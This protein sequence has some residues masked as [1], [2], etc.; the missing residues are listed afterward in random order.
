M[1]LRID[2]EE[3]V[4]R[5]WIS[6]AIADEIKAKGGKGARKGGAHSGSATKVD[7]QTILYDALCARLPGLP[8]WEK[9]GLIPGRKFRA[10][11]FISP[12]TIIEFDGFRYHSSKSAYQKDRDRG[13]LF[14]AN[15]F[16]VFHSYAKMVFDDALLAEF[17]ELVASTV[18]LPHTSAHS[19]ITEA[20]GA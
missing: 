2:P 14:E 20:A 4:K 15:G 13:N 18:E 8:E 11:I 10:D 1:S 7:P 5:G 16:R 12:N 3:A 19:M 17:V 9:G 6:R